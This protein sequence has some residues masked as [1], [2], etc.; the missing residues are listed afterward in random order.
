[1]R[2]KYL[3]GT[4]EVNGADAT[5]RVLSS[6]PMEI[7]LSRFPDRF[8]CVQLK[9]PELIFGKTRR[10]VDPRT[11]LAAYGPF[12]TATASSSRQLR[13]GIIGTEAGIKKAL[14]ILQEISQPIEQDPALDCILHPSFPGLNSGRPFSVDVV[15]QPSWHRSV[16]PQALRMLEVA[17]DEASK[18]GMSRELFAAQIRELSNLEIPPNLVVCAV[19]AKL[20]LSVLYAACA[21]SLPIEIIRDE[22]FGAVREDKVTQAWDR[23][24]RL[25]YKAGLPP[26]RL[27]D[28]AG[29]TCF[30]GLSFYRETQD[31][32]SSSWTCLARIVTDLGETF[33]VKGETFEWKPEDETEES[34]HLDKDYAAGLIARALEA[35]EKNSGCLPRKVVVHKASSYNQAERQGFSDSLLGIKEQAL[36]CVSRSGTFLLRPGRK[37]IFRGAAIPLGEKVGLVYLAGY[38]AFLRCY[39]GRSV[40]QPLEIKENWG[41]IAFR[42]AAK[43]MIRL[44]KL[45]WG[46]SNLHVDMPVTLNF[47]RN[48]LDVFKILVGEHILDYRNLL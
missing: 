38:A 24:I 37:P 7:H 12:A 1:M 16:S 21:E 4:S 8:E 6:P 9:E 5:R 18:L 45:E 34:P 33:F 35:Y 23:S 42:E 47:P 29:D 20:E 44:T 11:G 27:A 14:S 10:C 32:A 2:K 43:D 39:P 15:S 22:E 3:P 17:G 13:V 46:V 40:P 26:W 28:A 30:V 48:V 41:T 19:P 31:A 25:L 36:I